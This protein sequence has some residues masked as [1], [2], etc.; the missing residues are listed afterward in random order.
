M[1]SDSDL[2]VD[3]GGT[4]GGDYDVISVTGDVTIDGTVNLTLIG[5]YSPSINDEVAVLTWTG[6][7]TAD[8]VITPPTGWE[9]IV[10]ASSLSLR[11]TGGP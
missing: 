11:Y 5:A 10:G 9:T 7:L 6:T 3:I 4:A 8:N 2:N 1:D